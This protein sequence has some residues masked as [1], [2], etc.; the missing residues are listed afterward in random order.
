[1]VPFMAQGCCMAVED[2]VVLSRALDGVESAAQVSEAL[3]FYEAIRKDRTARIQ[4]ESSNNEWMK[5]QANADWLYAYDAWT[6]PI[7]S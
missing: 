1:M 6:T 2:A 4:R 7:G 5:G 3:S